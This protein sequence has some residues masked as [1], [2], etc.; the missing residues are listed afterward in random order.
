[1]HTG[2]PNI[3]F[4]NFG[5]NLNI[6]CW[7]EMVGIAG[8]LAQVLAQK[9]QISAHIANGIPRVWTSRNTFGK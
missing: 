8:M 1:M 7:I 9:N 4:A 5:K 2:R 6:L 3:H